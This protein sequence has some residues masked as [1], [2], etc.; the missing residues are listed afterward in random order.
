MVAV[1]TK[2]PAPDLTYLT[3]DAPGIHRIKT[4]TGFRYVDAAGRPVRDAETLARIKALVIPPAWTD[5]W[6]SPVADAHIQ[7]TGRDAR[8]RKQYTYH[9]RWREVRDR[10]K[11]ERTISFATAL[12]KIRERVEADLK[13]PGVSKEKVLAVVVS[14]LETTLIRVGNKEYARDNGSFGLTT[15]RDRHV[16]VNGSEVRFHFRGKSGKDHSIT[17]RDRRL[18]QLVKKCQD[19]PGQHLFQYIDEEGERRS[20]ESSDVNAYLREITGE[21]FTA[22]D[23]RT[24]AGTL[25]AATALQELDT[26]ESAAEAKRQLAG[27]VDSV[28]RKLGNT[29]TVCRTCYVHPDVIDEFLEGTLADTLRGQIENRLLDLPEGLGSDEAAVVALLQRR[30]ARR[31]RRRRVAA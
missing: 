6:I 31:K 28:A 27:A 19:L 26:F 15:M 13:K 24:W 14:L 4:K 5:V 29:P 21:D 17:L 2:P 11:Y 20:I 10:A 22:K 3:D 7:A 30:M 12:P 16:K 23:F 1:T 18:A 9:P 8:R 25:L